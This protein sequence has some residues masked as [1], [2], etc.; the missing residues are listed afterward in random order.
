MHV[1][2]SNIISQY[3]SYIIAPVCLTQMYDNNASLSSAVA[4]ISAEDRG[5]C[6]VERIL[7]ET[8]GNGSEGEVPNQCRK[9]EFRMSDNSWFRFQEKM[10]SMTVQYINVEAITKQ[11]AFATI[12]NII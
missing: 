7:L 4:A 11:K 10:H 5:L 3:I 2:K 9:S 8:F 6:G 1:V 12:G